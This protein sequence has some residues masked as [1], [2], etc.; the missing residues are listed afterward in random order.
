MEQDL[1]SYIRY[2]IRTWNTIIQIPNMCFVQPL[3]GNHIMRTRNIAL[4]VTLLRIICPYSVPVT[5]ITTIMP[6]TALLSRLFHIQK[7]VSPIRRS[8]WPSDIPGKVNLSL[9]CG[10]TWLRFS[11]VCAISWRLWHVIPCSLV[12][13]INIWKTVSTQINCNT[14]ILKFSHTQVICC[15]ER[16]VEGPVVQLCSEISKSL[17][18]RIQSNIF[19]WQRR[20]TSFSSLL[21]SCIVELEY[22]GRFTYKILYLQQECTQNFSFHRGLT[23]KLLSIYVWFQTLHYK[24][25]VI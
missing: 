20:S 25:H 1:I 2:Y 7:T 17:M 8:E 6:N 24:N 9:Q 5:I 3:S 19:H 18:Y 11:Q 22:R 23:L 13:N 21:F 14:R 16:V 4:C 12:I 10:T 15:M